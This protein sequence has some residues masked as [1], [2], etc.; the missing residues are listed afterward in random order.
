MYDRSDDV[1]KV[2]IS[3]FVPAIEME[4]ESYVPINRKVGTIKKYILSS[5]SQLSDGSYEKDMNSVTFIDK[6]TGKIFENNDN[7]KDSGIT[8]GTKIV[9][10]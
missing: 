9:I 4:F 8:N 7:V 10:I 2:L 1:N 3:V 6:S 5:L